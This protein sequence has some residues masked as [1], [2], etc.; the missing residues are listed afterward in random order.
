MLR[1]VSSAC[2]QTFLVPTTNV[3]GGSRASEPRLSSPARTPRRAAATRS[4]S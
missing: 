2:T 3:A 4:A 1:I